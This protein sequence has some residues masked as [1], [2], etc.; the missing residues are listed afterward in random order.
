[1]LK[2][3]FKQISS[4]MFS[5]LSMVCAYSS[6]IFLLLLDIES[7]EARLIWIPHGKDLKESSTT[8]YRKT[9]ETKNDKQVS[10]IYK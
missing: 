1:M 7:V 8:H 3:Q 6:I 5:L 2:D 4:N 9:S 10:K